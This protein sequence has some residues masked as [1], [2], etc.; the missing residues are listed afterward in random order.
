MR[1]LI[2]QAITPCAG[3]RVWFTRLACDI[4]YRVKEWGGTGGNFLSKFYDFFPEMCLAMLLCLHSKLEI[5][6]N[7]QTLYGHNP[8]YLHKH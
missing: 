7:N 3:K 2:L 6:S 4:G 5:I 1:A 8:T